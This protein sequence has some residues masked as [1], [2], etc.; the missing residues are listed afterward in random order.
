MGISFLGPY[1]NSCR[2]ASGNRTAG[3]AGP[4]AGDAVPRS[5]GRSRERPA[6]A[7]RVRPSLLLE[8]AE[9]LRLVLFRQFP[10]ATL[11]PGSESES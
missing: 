5:R 10:L 7:P 6:P 11:R 1:I 9:G 8:Q 4:R 3:R 2:A